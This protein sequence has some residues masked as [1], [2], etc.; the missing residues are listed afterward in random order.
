M[1]SGHTQF[2]YSES[3]R[4]AFSIRSASRGEARE[5]YKTTKLSL[6]EPSKTTLFHRTNN[7]IKQMFLD[8]DFMTLVTSNAI[9]LLG[10]NGK[11]IKSIPVKKGRSLV[12]SN[13]NSQQHLF[14]FEDGLLEIF[15]PESKHI[16]RSVLP[17]INAKQIQVARH[18]NFITLLADSQ[19][20]IYKLQD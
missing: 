15:Q 20:Y 16:I 18:K 6:K 4:A 3:Q 11:V 17:A 7:E 19:F 1:L 12:S 13:I 2:R 8:D 10:Y 5:V 9:V 14:L